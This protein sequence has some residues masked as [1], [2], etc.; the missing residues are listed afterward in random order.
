MAAHEPTP[1]PTAGIPQGTALDRVAAL[2]AALAAPLGL[3]EVLEVVATDA[4]RAI[5]ARAVCVWLRHDDDLR[6]AAVRGEQ[7]PPPGHGHLP[8]DATTPVA[9]AV[10]EARPRFGVDGDPHRAV[11]PFVLHG[12]GTG[13][14]AVTFESPPALDGD[15]VAFLSAVADVC[16]SALE[17]ARLWEAERAARDRAER[18]YDRLQFLSEAGRAAFSTL[19]ATAGLQQVLQL[20]VPRL[21]DLA[22]AYLR[23]GGS[24]RRVALVH[25]D[26]EVQRE[27]RRLVDVDPLPVSADLPAAECARTGEPRRLL[28]PGRT[29][30]PHLPADVVERLRPLDLRSWIVVPLRSPRAIEGVLVFA[31]SGRARVASD[32]E[33]DV[34]VEVGVRAGIAVEH[35][36]R[37]E[38]QVAVAEML[39]RA[40]LPES[41]PRLPG[42]ALSAEYLPAGPRSGREVGGDWYDAIAHRDGRVGLAVGDVSGHGLGAA[43]TMGRLRTAL[44]VYALEGAPP[45]GVLDRL[46]RF[47]HDTG[48]GELVTAVYGVIDPVTGMLRWAAAGHPPP[49]LAGADGHV[50]ELTPPR[51]PVLGAI[52]GARY[53]EAELELTAG[54]TLVLYTDGLVERRGESIDDGLARLAR[55]LTELAADPDLD[56][57]VRGLA[58]LSDRD[59]DVC[60]LAVRRR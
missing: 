2:A 1:G 5:G 47:L 41:L 7:D 49:F 43:A 15:A 36:R 10:R 23:D 52:A 46:N 45:A 57:V 31:V 25:R 19:D 28:D 14:L 22:I 34:A 8:V 4:G 56:A 60:L 58:S 35:G 51:G 50:A 26:P 30:F 24:L 42:L 53:H 33:L 9:T 59:D 44:R 39:Q 6:A 18:A 3:G 27:L 16:G 40:V 55:R 20:S 13:A 48:S 12:R 38:D 37:Y 17:R 32:R 21:A 11:L 54:D 29:L